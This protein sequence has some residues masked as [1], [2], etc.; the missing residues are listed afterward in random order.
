MNRPAAGTPAAAAPANALAVG[1]AC[2][3]FASVF[4]GMNIPFTAVLFETFDPFFMAAVRVAFATLIL[5]GLAAATLG[6]RAFGVP[7]PASRFATMTLAMASFFV[8]YNLGLR[9]TNPITAAAIMAGS[10]V[11][12]A[13]TV[14]LLTG[15]ALEPGFRGAA[16]L[17]IAGA[18]IAI[19]G[20]GA[21]AGEGLRLQGGEPL[22][23][24]SLV[25]WTVYSIYAQR[26]FETHVPQLRRTYVS[27]LGTAFWLALAW[28]VVYALGMVETPNL[29]PDA[30]AITF[31]LATAVFSTALGGVAWNIGV[32]RVGLIAGALWQNTV[33]VFGVLIAMLFGFIPTA[34]Q[35]LG[36]AVVIAGVLYMQWRKFQYARR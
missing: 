30:R 15:A 25:S 36:G 35:I 31:L 16:L 9:Y 1:T 18:G 23:V 27:M 8:L 7:M 26:W 10:P 33:P 2:Y 3:L 4:W 29:A 14:R 28:G 12:A 22:I 34:A 24:L 17:T 32:N 13:I 6:W 11:Y 21:A 5:G 20:R 19:Y